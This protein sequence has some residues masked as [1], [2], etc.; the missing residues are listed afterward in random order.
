MKKALAPA[1]KPKHKGKPQGVVDIVPRPFS[2]CKGS[3]SPC[4]ITPPE[5]EILPHAGPRGDHPG[6]RGRGD[7]L[8]RKIAR[9]LYRTPHAGLR[10]AFLGLRRV[11]GYRGNEI[12]FMCEILRTLGRPY[13]ANESFFSIGIFRRFGRGKGPFPAGRVLSLPCGERGLPRAST[14]LCARV[15]VRLSRMSR[16]TTSKAVSDRLVFF[17]WGGKAKRLSHFFHPKIGGVLRGR[18]AAFPFPAERTRGRQSAR[19]YCSPNASRT[20]CTPPAFPPRFPARNTR[21]TTPSRDRPHPPRSLF[22]VPERQAFPG[23]VARPAVPL[24]A[25]PGG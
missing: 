23:E 8:S 15:C 22:S 25:P 9:F 16:N 6:A 11:G 14:G 7:P 2:F 20:A 1:A 17:R 12:F 4:P 13:N 10:C 24:C 19:N 21:K 5:L 3:G 18:R